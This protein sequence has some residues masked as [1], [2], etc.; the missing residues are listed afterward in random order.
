MV[1][2]GGISGLM[3]MMFGIFKM[4]NQIVVVGIDDKILKCQVV[5]ID[6]MMCDECCYFDLFKVSCKKC[7]VVGSGQSVEYVNK[8]FKM[9]WN[10]VDVMK[11]MG[12]GK[13]GLFVG[14]V[15][16]MGFGGG[17]K[18]FLFEEMKVLQEKM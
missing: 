7:I 18:M 9:Y 16:V 14:I 3:G 13:C 8:L 6:F 1:N 4:K 5:I 2:M 10:M 12:L 15:Q 11:V 17:M